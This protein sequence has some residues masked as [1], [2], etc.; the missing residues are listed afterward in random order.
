[1]NKDNFLHSSIVDAF[2][3]SIKNNPGK[4]AILGDKI[5]ITYSQLQTE[6]DLVAQNLYNRGF[7]GCTICIDITPSPELIIC[8][9]GVLKVNCSYICFDNKTPLSRKR[10]IIKQSESKLIIS[11]KNDVCDSIRFDELSAKV[12]VTGFKTAKNKLTTIIYTSGSTGEPKGVM[13]SHENILSFIEATK[14]IDGTARI[15]QF[16]SVAFDAFQ[17]EL[18]S[19]LLNGGT[20]CLMPPEVWSN[21]HKA[22]ESLK[23]LEVTTAF[24]TTALINAGVLPYF[25]H[26]DSFN[27]LFFG[28]EPL[29]NN[30]ISDIFSKLDFEL[31]HCYGPTEACIWNVTYPVTHDSFPLPL[32]KPL[33]NA[34]IKLVDEHLND[35]TLPNV[36]GEILIGGQ[37]VTLGYFKDAVQ[38]QEKFIEI[39]Q[40]RYYKTSDIAYFNEECLL[41]Y[42]HRTDNTIKFN[43]FRVNLTEI[44]NMVMQIDK[45]ICSATV[46][47]KNNLQDQIITFYCASE[48]TESD[49]QSWLSQHLPRYMQPNRLI[50]VKQ[51][52]HTVSG[53]VDRKAL[54]A[55]ITDACEA[56]DTHD[57]SDIDGQICQ[58]WSKLLGTNDIDHDDRF[59]DVGG[60]SVLILKLQREVNKA[61]KIKVRVTELFKKPSIKEQA[62]LVKSLVCQ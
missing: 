38:T 25:Q 24:I 13:V 20:L 26:I 1:M 62:E 15:A 59:F 10:N 37:C 44:D 53:K 28:G 48:L 16:S 6:S 2:E 4:V 56:S 17:F 55:Q 7:I 23:D 31:I 21:P 29:K 35:I 46:L 5:E 58:I 34:T 8:I 51:F 60:S 32:G 39:D 54:L 12:E 45:Q 19:A 50:R 57:A 33:S 11:S 22:Q 47:Y 49:I 3:Q 43:G 41:V 61:F 18:W 52:P 42:S 9:L 30:I 14:N 27:R 40:Q 36:H